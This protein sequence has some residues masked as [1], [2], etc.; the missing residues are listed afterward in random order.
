MSRNGRQPP[1][2][3]AIGYMDRWGMPGTS[4]HYAVGWAWAGDTP[5][6]WTKQ[7]A[8]HFGGTRNAMIV[9]WPKG[10]KDTGKVRSQFHHCIDVMP[11]I[12]DI[13]GINEPEEV[14][15][16]IQKPIEGTSF[17]STFQPSNADRKNGV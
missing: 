11:T 7:V 12:M 9:S 15:G 4:P 8:S 14:N 10:I 3:S 1:I 2:D 17:A 16:Y 13:V 5:F 6:Q